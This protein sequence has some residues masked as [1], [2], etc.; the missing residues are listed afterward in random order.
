MYFKWYI[1]FGL[2]II[3]LI[4]GINKINMICKIKI[5][6]EDCYIELNVNYLSVLWGKNKRYKYIFI[7]MIV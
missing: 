3:L 5:K 4:L 6:L 7:W 1:L 2:Y